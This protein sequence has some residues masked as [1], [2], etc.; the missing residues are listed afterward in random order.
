MCGLIGSKCYGRAILPLYSFAR[1]I[2]SYHRHHRLSH[3]THCLLQPASSG[4]ANGCTMLDILA[5]TD[6]FQDNQCSDI[7]VELKSLAT[8]VL[9]TALIG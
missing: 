5:R 8:R 4:N 1:S 6:C 7:D 9:Q 3:N 2:V